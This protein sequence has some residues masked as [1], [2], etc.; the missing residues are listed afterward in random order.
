MELIILTEGKHLF[1]KGKSVGDTLREARL[2]QGLQLGDLETIT[3][4]PAHH[5]LALELDQF[6]LVPE[7][8]LEEYLTRYAQSVGLD[9]ND[10]SHQRD[11]QEA[12]Q[13]T[14]T[15]APKPEPRVI[16]PAF[17]DDFEDE[18]D[19]EEEDYDIPERTVHRRRRSHREASQK[20]SAWPTIILCLLAIGIISIVSYFTIKEWPFASNQSTPEITTVS[21]TTTTEVTS[22]TTTVTEREETGLSNQAAD[23]F[24]TVTAKTTK[25]QVDITFTLTDAESWVSVSNELLGEQSATLSAEQKDFTVSVA[26]GSSSFITVG[27]PS[28]VDV[29]VD[30]Q[31]IDTTDI[32]NNSP[33][34]FTLVVE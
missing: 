32:I 17:S 27:I 7:E 3:G 25:K 10:I 22:E 16:K 1:M 33:G 24:L 19:N 21:E 8:A 4:I 31:K 30:G 6:A 14:L 18:S 34:N 26:K 23:G 20:K 12:F 5:L 13:H 11:D 15:P 28:G 2:Q 9:A 29:T